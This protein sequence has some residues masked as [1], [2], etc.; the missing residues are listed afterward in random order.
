M[1]W[2]N[3]YTG[4]NGFEVYYA[5]NDVYTVVVT[6]SVGCSYTLQVDLT[7]GSGS[8]LFTSGYSGNTSC[9][10]CNGIIQVNSTGGSAPYYYN[11]NGSGWGTQSSW[12]NLCPGTYVI[13]TMDANGC[14]ANTITYLIQSSTP[15]IVNADIIQNE[16]SAGASDGYVQASVSGGFGNETITLDGV[17]GNN[18]FF[19]NLSSGYYLLCATEGF[20]SDCDTI[21]VGTDSTLNCTID[22]ISQVITPSTNGQCNG[23][24]E[25]TVTGTST[26]NVAW[27]DCSTDSI[28]YT[29][30][31]WYNACP[32]SYYAVVYDY[33][34]GCSDTSL[35]VDATDSLGCNLSYQIDSLIPS[36]G[37]TMQDG[38]IAVQA[39]NG[40]GPY[41]YD[42]N[43]MQ[44]TSGQFGNL[45]PGSY[46][47]CITDTYNNC[48]HCDTVD[49]PYVN[50]INEW[51]ESISAYPN[52][53]KNELM[54]NSEN[55]I[56]GA[57]VLLYD[58][59]GKLLLREVITGNSHKLNLDEGL[60]TGMYLLK[61]KFNNRESNIR[62]IRE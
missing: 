31:Q 2:G 53:F 4:T 48:V 43:G 51:A 14:Y 32:G 6:D 16:S 55:D 9:G 1:T 38:Y 8:N 30:P 57:E 23:Q 28:A 47:L 36:S 29:A 45:L 35:C 52:P 40:V 37:P 44:S 22:I 54:L 56:S 24:L 21:W 58:M 3:G 10:Q 62:L 46:S 7:Q 60:S 26:Y 41:I 5:N 12:S 25:A 15:F 19:G 18:G 13:E 34:T 17:V 33:Q 11:L 59:Y 39:T 49:I 50:G 42:L 20:C 61:L 27:Y